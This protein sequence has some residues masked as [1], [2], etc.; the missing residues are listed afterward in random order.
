M[1]NIY[2]NNKV[3]INKL[4]LLAAVAAF[5]A[6]AVYLMGYIAPFV[7][8]YIIS[9]ILS[10][11]VSLV[12]NK[13][14]IHRGV[15][16]AVLILALIASIGFLGYFLIGRLIEEVGAFAQDI[17]TYIAN[18]QVLFGNIS[19]SLENSFG[20]ADFNIDFDLLLTQLLSL[21]TGLLQGLLEGGAF[22]TAIPFAILRVLLAIISAFFFIKDKELIKQSVLALL[23]KRLIFRANIVRKGVIR[24]LVGY[25]KGQLIVMSYV[26]TISV[27]GLTII[28]SPYS[29][30]VGIGIGVF[31][32]IPIFGAGGILIPWAIYNILG[33]NLSFAIGLFIIYG[34]IFLA[35]Q[36]L[37]PRV[38]GNQ[39]GMHPIL[40]L[41]SVYVG[42]ITMGPIGFFAGPLIALTVKIIMESNLTSLTTDSQSKLH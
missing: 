7:A 16:A 3:F 33:G 1:R 40:L 9:L 25:A 12:H 15:A 28:G 42:I 29:L 8:G 18:A 21:A 6:S 17:P 10:P 4:M 32:L 2:Q 41:M 34:V 19:A 27:V 23:P 35:R 37:E 20:A 30:F 11:L 38:V 31:D 26:S 22:F 14:R 5:M 13:W 39:I 24:A 36:I